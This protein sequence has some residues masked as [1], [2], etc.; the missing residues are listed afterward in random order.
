MASGDTAGAP[1][2]AMRQP[3]KQK[4]AGKAQKA[5][6]KKAEKSLSEKAQKAGSGK[7]KVGRKSKQAA[8][9]RTTGRAED[10]EDGAE[11]VAKG[12]KGSRKGKAET[13]DRQ[14]QK[15]VTAKR[16]GW[17]NKADKEEQ[18]ATSSG[19]PPSPVSLTKTR[20]ARRGRKAFSD[21]AAEQDDDDDDG[22]DVEAA[23]EAVTAAA[24]HSPE[25]KKTTAAK[26]AG[27][28][29]LRAASKVKQGASQG[30]RKEAKAKQPSTRQ[31]PR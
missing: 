14:K 7:A 16:A 11:G 19:L 30:R 24:A 25:K 27:K 2:N 1:G 5:G 17:S 18:S 8:N 3:A 13:L 26:G 9:G 15:P 23:T 31:Q 6:V 4:A 28:A 29:G 12:Q 20:P 22:D 10:D 21:N